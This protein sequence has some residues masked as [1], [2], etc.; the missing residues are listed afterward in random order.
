[1]SA[2]GRQHV[3]PAASPYYPQGNEPSLPLR[4]AILA[5]Y[6]YCYE[7]N[8]RNPDLRRWKQP[9]FPIARD[10][11][12]PYP[13]IRND[14]LLTRAR[15]H[16]TETR[17]DGPNLG[18]RHDNIARELDCNKRYEL[19]GDTY[20]RA[21]VMDAILRRYNFLTTASLSKL[22]G[23]LVANQL[24]SWF[25]WSYAI[26]GAE[27]LSQL[28]VNG[29]NKFDAQATCADLF[30]AYLGALVLDRGRDVAEEWIGKLSSE[31][32][33]YTFANE[34]E[35][36][37]AREHTKITAP[38]PTNLPQPGPSSAGTGPAMKRPRSVPAATASC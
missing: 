32:V 31:E 1:M 14:F 10:K 9:C 22:V 30:E 28:S 8:L 13:I 18:G 6:T 4:N 12:P 20:L 15:R 23:L 16:I 35:R 5:P 25:A 24:I 3:A 21:F 36:E 17:G 11:L 34:V 38:L 29:R 19:L 33:L 2:A 27:D 7:L 26:F 37:R